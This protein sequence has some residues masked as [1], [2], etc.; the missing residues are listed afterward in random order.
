M[1]AEASRTWM[2]PLRIAGTP[3]LGSN[4]SVSLPSMLSEAASFSPDTSLTATASTA[5]RQRTDW[6]SA[7]TSPML[8]AAKLPS[9]SSKLV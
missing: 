1:A 5:S 3:T 4:G 7:T 8:G 9:K 2:P 6:A